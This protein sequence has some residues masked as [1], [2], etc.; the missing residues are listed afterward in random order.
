[1]AA[2]RPVRRLDPDVFDHRPQRA[3]NLSTCVPRG[4]AAGEIYRAL[5]PTSWDVD[6]QTAVAQ[7]EQE[8]REVS[9]AYH[10]IA[11]TGPSGE[12]I[13]VDTTRP[14]L[15]PACVALIAHPSD[16]RYQ[17]L[18]ETSATTPLFGMRVPIHPHH[19]A[20]PAKGTGIV[21]VCTYGDATDV[22]WQRELNLPM[23]PMIGRD[24]RLIAL[25]LE[26]GQEFYDTLVG[27][28]L[29][30]A[31]R[32]IVE[33]LIARGELIGDPRPITH[34]VKFYEKGDRPLEIVTSEQWFIRT[35]AHR[36]GLL[37]AGRKLR[38]HPESMRQ[39]Y[40]DW[41]RGLNSDWLISRQRFFGVP[42]PVWYP[43][44]ADGRPQFDAPILPDEATLPVDPRRDA[45]TR[46]RRIGSRSAGRF[47]RRH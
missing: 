5:A 6:F 47:H 43:I 29:N 9:G 2:A 11:F 23:R 17:H 36:D 41:V 16:Q 42:F 46:I 28:N 37:A 19:L 1:M 13:A 3:A 26:S 35:L 7:A 38:W 4:L 27:R 34:V 12:Q 18:F 21:M 20:D 33:Q 8:E 39:R 44:D 14:E 45:A 15:L 31:R 24:G 40:E 10:R 22:L 25:A 30:Q 32:S